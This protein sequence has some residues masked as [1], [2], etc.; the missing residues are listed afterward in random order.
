ML[1]LRRGELKLS[2]EELTTSFEQYYKAT[3][4]TAKIIDELS[5]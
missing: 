5:V 1:L 2:K 3:E 4:R